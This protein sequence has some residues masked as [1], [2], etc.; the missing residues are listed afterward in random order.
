MLLKLLL[1]ARAAHQFLA[2]EQSR[3]AVALGGPLGEAD[4]VVQVFG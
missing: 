4:D 1:D 3:S 2:V